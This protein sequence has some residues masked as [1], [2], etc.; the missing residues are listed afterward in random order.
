L[1]TLP[2]SPETGGAS[3][4]G[5]TVPTVAAAGEGLPQGRRRFGLFEFDVRTGELRREGQLVKL[6][7][8]PAKVLTLLLSQP[9]EV[10][11][12]DDLRKKLWGDE[13]FVDFERGLNFC[14]LQVRTALGDSSDNP[15]FVQTVPRRGYRFI[16]PVADSDARPEPSLPAPPQQPVMRDDAGGR[17]QVSGRWWLALL[18]TVAVACLGAW[19]TFSR[20]RDVRAA[21]STAAPV[22]LVILPFIDLTGEPG[23]APM[24]DGLTDEVISEVGRLGR[25]GVA[26]IAR[27]SAMSYRHSSKTIAQ[28]G[29]ELNAAFAVETSVRREGDGVRIDSSLVSARDQTPIASWTETFGGAGAAAADSQTGAA[30]RLAR[31]IAMTLVPDAAAAQVRQPTVPLGAW[32]AYLQGRALMASGSIDDVRQAVERFEAASAQAPELAPAWAKLAETKH[33][34]VMVGAATPADAY[35]GAREAARRALAADPSLADAHLADGLVRFWHDWNPAEAA[36]AF[37]RALA[38]NG[39]SAAAHHDYA[40]ALLAQGRE[41]AA[42]AHITTARDLDPLSTRANNDIGWLYLQLRRPADAARAC[43]HTLAIQPANLEAQGCLE[44]AYAQRGMYDLALR[45]A[46]ATLPSTTAQPPAGEPRD[47]KAALEQIWQWRLNRLEQAA[48]RRAIGAYNVAVQHALVGNR[49]RALDYLEQAYAERANMMVLIERDPAVDT[50][51][52]D[53]RFAAL[54]RQITAGSR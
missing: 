47:A 51:R 25:A 54:R 22:R 11:L 33:L 12:R 8:Q 13:T 2:R 40:W 36:K 31:L 19:A 44:R 7:P 42:I 20:S 45:A 10:V 53:P 46:R 28:I 6:S 48:S 1:H 18:A 38:L 32:N 35:P 4:V 29:A 26:V 39:S 24:V 21:A 15:R 49:G 30:I 41:A 27:T 3:I 14:V 16:A 5:V 34:L 17:V 23:A 43:Q 52:T 9:G 50:L 37:E